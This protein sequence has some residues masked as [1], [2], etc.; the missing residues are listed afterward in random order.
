VIAPRLDLLALYP[1]IMD[2]G[3]DTAN[4]AVLRVRAEWEGV[5][6]RVAVVPFESAL[7][8]TRPDVV[9]LGSGA[10]EDL[11]VVSAQLAVIADALRDWVAAGTVLLAVGSGLD[12]LARGWERAAG[13]VVAGAGVF[14]GEALLLPR[15]T[16][17]EIVVAW[18]PDVEP[19]VGYENHSR[20]YLAGP[21]ESALGLARRGVGN[22]TGVE[23]VE[24]GSAVGTHLHG[25]I[26]ARNPRFADHLLDRAMSARHGSGFEPRSAEA[27][28]ADALAALARGRTF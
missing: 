12:L 1:E 27:G 7:P 19:L 26:A 25:P 2:V 20:G 8:S 13:D 22:G 6:A 5:D 18:G 17:G 11:V 4:L 9:L 10:D 23:G 15:R 24:Q 3:A 14:A 28:H 16:S 21:G